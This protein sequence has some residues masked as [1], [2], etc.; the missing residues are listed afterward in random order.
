[1]KA[2]I[3]IILATFVALISSLGTNQAQS[4]ALPLTSAQ[5]HNSVCLDIGGTL[6]CNLER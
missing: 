1:M 5:L 3:V 4:G 2:L 6:P